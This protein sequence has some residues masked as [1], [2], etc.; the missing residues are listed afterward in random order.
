MIPQIKKILYATDLTK[1]S[2]FAFYFAADMAR[3][4]DAKIIILHCIPSIPPAV[5][6][7]G[8]LTNGDKTLKKIKET[9]REQ[10]VA[11]IEARLRD[12]CQQAETELGPLVWILYPRSS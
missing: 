5:Y 8:G 6:Y 2:S 11:E 7:E 1:N 9:E 3:K 12:F 4:Y 10:Y